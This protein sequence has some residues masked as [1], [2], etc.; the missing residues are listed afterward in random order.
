MSTVGEN[1]SDL[2]L[3][4]LGKIYIKTGNS[5]KL[6]NDVI[7]QI[8]QS[9]SNNSDDY[10]KSITTFTPNIDQVI[11]PEDGHFIFD[12]S[13]KC[14]YIVVNSTPIL[15]M[16]TQQEE[17]NGYVKKSGDT[18]TGPITFNTSQIPIKLNTDIL[19]PRLNAEEINGY[20]SNQ[21]AIKSHDEQITGN[22]EFTDNQKFDKDI[23]LN[24]SIG[25]PTFADGFS[26]YG[27]RL[28][29]TT[30][31]LTVDN[32][33]VRKTMQVYELI[34]NEINATNGSLMVTNSSKIAN[35]EYLDILDDSEAL[36]NQST[37]DK[38]NSLSFNYPVQ[39]YDIGD[40][41][42]I[43]IL[44]N[45]TVQN[46]VD[47]VLDLS[48]QYTF[49]IQLYNTNGDLLDITNY[50]LDINMS[51]NKDAIISSITV[52]HDT[53]VATFIVT[54]QSYLS[55]ITITVHNS[56]Q[57]KFQINGLGDDSSDNLVYN[58]LITYNNVVNIYDNKAENILNKSFKYIQDQ[59]EY[60]H[61]TS[62][63]VQSKI[64]T[65]YIYEY[66]YRRG[67]YYIVTMKEDNYPTLKIGDL[68]RCQK[69]NQ[70]S[71]SIKYYDAIVL[72]HF[73]TYKY[74]I[75]LLNTGNSNEQDI[76][77]DTPSLDTNS[78]EATNSTT[79]TKETS[80]NNSS[81]NTDNINNIIGTKEVNN[82]GASVEQDKQKVYSSTTNSTDGYSPIPAIGDALVQIGSILDTD[83]QGA[84]YI[85]NSDSYAP[86]V[87]VMANIYRPDFSVLYMIPD[88][89]D[90]NQ[91]KT[92]IITNEEGNQETVYSWKYDKCTKARLGNLQ[93]IKDSTFTKRKWY[94]N[95][96]VKTHYSELGFSEDPISDTDSDSGHYYST[97]AINGYGLYSENV[98][99]TGEFYLNNGKSV[100]DFSQDGIYEKYGNAGLYI[101]DDS[102]GG[103]RIRINANKIYIT[104]DTNLDTYTENKIEDSVKAGVSLDGNN[105][106]LFGKEIDITGAVVFHSL[107]TKTYADTS[108]Q[109]A[110]DNITVGGKNIFDGTNKGKTNWNYWK[111]T[112][113]G[114]ITIED[115][116]SDSS[117]TK[118]IVDQQNINESAFIYFTNINR[119]SILNNVQ[120]TLSFDIISTVN[121]TLYIKIQKT[122][123][124]DALIDFGSK[125]ISENINE[126][127]VLTSTTN[128]KT[129]IGQVL[130]I[131]GIKTGTF[132]IKNLKFEIGNKATDWTASANDIS[133]EA[134]D[135]ADKALDAAKTYVA[136]NFVTATLHD[137]DLA[138]L[139]SQ[140]DGAIDTWFYDYVPTNTNIPA[141][142]WTDDATRN[143]HLGDLFYETST[144]YCYRYMLSNSVYSWSRVIDSDATTALAN[145]A[146]AQDTADHKRRIFVVTPI[147]P[148]DVGDMW[149]Q[150]TNGDILICK[151]AKTSTET[152]SI[153]DW[154]LASKY[155]DD[156]TA[157][158]AQ[159]AANAA[160]TT[161]NTAAA[162][163]TSALGTLSN[164]TSDNVLSVS[165]K[166]S[167]KQAWAVVLAEKQNILSQATYFSVSSTDYQNAF[168]ALANYLNNGVTWVSGEPSWLADDS[169]NT[170]I[171][172]DTYRQNWTNLYTQRTLLLNAISTKAKDLADAAQTDATKA[173][174]DASD[175]WNYAKSAKTNA[176]VALGTLSDIT[177]DNILS[178]NEKPAER[179]EWNIVLAEKNSIDLSADTF[180]VSRVSYDNAFTGLANYL[181]NGV[182]WTSG[183][184][185]WLNDTNINSNTTI[186]GTTYRNYWQQYYTTRTTLLNAI[187]DKARIQAD[188]AKDAADDAKS[189][190]DAAQSTA[191]TAK[192]TADSAALLLNTITDDSVLSLNEKPTERQ[193]WDILYNEKQNILNQASTFGI[194]S[195]SYTDAF[196]DLANYLNNGTTWTSGEP[197]WLSDGQLSVNTNIVSSTY[198]S[199][200][201]AVYTARTV[202]LNLIAAKAKTL[203]D[204]AQTDATKALDDAS[205]AFNAAGKAQTDAT[206]ALG[207]ITNIVSDNVLSAAEKSTERKE[208]NIIAAEKSNIDTQANTFGI[209]RTTYDD[210]FQSLATYLNNNTTYTSGIPFWLSDTQLS[211]NT[212]IDG[213]AYR[214]YWSN[215][216]TA[217]TAL[218]NA[219]ASKARDLAKNAQTSA[220]SG[221]TKA[222]NAQKTADAAQA[223]A[224]SALGTLGEITNDNILSPNEKQ[225]ELKEW[226]VIQ[227]EK[228]NID[229]QAG[230][231]QISATAYDTAYTN[232]GTYLNNGVT[233]PTNTTPSTP[234]WFSNLTTN[235]TIDG[236]TYRSKWEAYYEQRTILL[237]ALA[238]KAKDTADS[239][240]TSA[241]AA[242]KAAD[243]AAD[244]ASDA[245][246]KAI[247][248]L[249][250]IGNIVSD[251]ILSPAEK[252]S[253][254]QA[255]NQIVS[256][257]ES[258]D[259]EATTYQITTTDKTN[260]DNYFTALGT[261][262][263]GGTALP[264]GNTP[265]WF[266]DL[267]SNTTIVGTT[268]RSN[269]Q[270]YYSARTTLLNKITAQAKA[271]A[272]QA[273][274]S[275]TDDAVNGIQI[276]GTNLILYSEVHNFGSDS[277]VYDSTNHIWTI[278]IP[279]AP[280]NWGYGFVFGAGSRTAINPGEYLT[281]SCEIYS[282][283]AFTLNHDINNAANDGN[284]W[285]GND[286]DDRSSETNSGF[287]NLLSAGVWHK[288]WFTIKARTDKTVGIQN[289]N[290][291]IGALPQNSA[292]T[293]KV[294]HIKIEKG[295]KATDWTPAPE[296]VTAEVKAAQDSADSANAA[297]SD[298]SNDNK[299]TA[300]EKST[301]RK[302]WDTIYGEYDGI[303]SQAISFGVSY[304]NYTDALVVLGTYLNNNV[305]YTISS[306]STIP[307]LINDTN[308]S[309]TSDINGNTFR[310]NF[311]SFYNERQILLNSISTKSKE[312][313]KTAQDTA[314]QAIDDASDAFNSAH[315]A[316]LALADISNDDLLTP[317]E[318]QTVRKDWDAIYTQYES[319]LTKA[320][321]AVPITSY[322]NALNTLGTYLNN[323]TSYTISSTIPVWINDANLST[324]QSLGTNGGSSFRSH[325]AT[326]YN[327]RQQF[328]T[329]LV[330]YAKQLANTAQNTVDNMQ[331][332]GRNLIPNSDN[333]FLDG[334][335]TYPSSIPCQG[336]IEGWYKFNINTQL[337]G[338]E[339]VTSNTIAITQTGWISESVY[340]KT[341]GILGSCDITFYDNTTGH[342]IIIATIINMGNGI[343]RMEA[344][345]NNPNS[346]PIRT[347]DLFIDT[348][349]AT[350]ISFRYP[351]L[352]Y[353][354]KITD[355]SPAPEDVDALISQAQ[356]TADKAV[357][358]STS[359]YA[360][361]ASSTTAPT[362]GWNTTP[363]TWEQGYY[364]WVRTTI[365]Y[366]DN[367]TTTT[368]PVVVTGNTGATGSGVSI[369]STSITYA[370]SSDSTQPND[371][372]FTYSTVP[373][374][375]T[376]NYLWSKTVVIYSDDTETKSYSVS[377]TG[378]NGTSV[379]ILSTSI[380][381]QV[382]GNGTTVPT[383]TWSGT[384]P[385]AQQGEYLWTKT[386]VNYSDSTSTTTYS[387]AKQ[388][389]TGVGV[390]SITRYYYSTSQS[391]P[392]IPTVLNPPSP[393]TVNEPGYVSGNYLYYT[394]RVL[395][396]DG[397]FSYS[398]VQL[399][400]AYVAAAQANSLLADIS[401]DNKLTPSEKN[402][403]LKEWVTIQ[404]E[405]TPIEKQATT[406]SVDYANYNTAYNNL[407]SYITPLL[408]NM[409]TTSM[410]DSGDNFR[411]KFK[412]YYN[413]RTDLLNAISTMAKTL[414]ENAQ[415]TADN[416]QI[417]G[418][419]LLTNS[420]TFEGYVNYSNWSRADTDY[421]GL[422]VFYRNAQWC[423]L[424]QLYNVVAGKTY[425][426][427]ANVTGDDRC[428][429]YIYASKLDNSQIAGIIQGTYIGNITS[430]RRIRI[431]FTPTESAT[432]YIRVENSVSDSSLNVCGYK[433][434][435]GN[436]A[437]DWSPAPEDIDSQIQ[438]VQLDADSAL[439]S[440]SDISNDKK[441][442][443]LEKQTVN[444]DWLEIQNEYLEYV[445]EAT[446]IGVSTTLYTSY[447]N[448]LST[449]ITPLLSS[450]TSTSNID[451]GDF[452]TNF[453]NYY[454]YRSAL[455][456]AISAK[457]K[458]DTDNIQ[459][460]GVN[461]I[462]NSDQEIVCNQNETNHETT[463]ALIEFNKTYTV[464]YF[465]K[466]SANF[467][468]QTSLLQLYD[469]SGNRIVATWFSDNGVTTVYKRFSHTFTITDSNDI[470]FSLGLRNSASSNIF[471]YY[472]WKLEEGNRATTWTPAIED[473][474]LL[475]AF[476]QD[477][478]VK[479][480]L[481]QTSA[482]F[483]G[484]TDSEGARHTMA[485]TNGIPIAGS[486]GQSIAAWYGGEMIDRQQYD[487]TKTSHYND[488]ATID[489]NA[490]RT[491]FRMDGSGYTA[492]GNLTWDERGILTI[493]QV[494]WDNEDIKNFFNAFSVGLL[495]DKLQITPKG[496]FTALTVGGEKV[497]TLNTL[498]DDT[499]YWGATMISG[500]VTGDINIGGKLYIGYDTTNDAVVFYKSADGG[501]TKEA[502]N[503]YSL[504]GLSAFGENTNISSGGTSYD[505][506]DKWSDY[507]ADKATN[508]L[509]ALLGNDLN[510]RVSKLEGTTLTSVD[511][512]IITNKPST[513]TPSSH[514]HLW[515]DITDH[516]TKLSAFTNDS[517]F[518]TN[519]GTVTSVGLSV[520]TGLSVSGSP[521][522][523]SGTLVIALATG[524]S[525]PTTAKQTN[526]DTAFT[527]NHTHANKTVLDGITS[528]LVANWNTA[529]TNSHTHSNKS[530]LDGITSTLVSNWNS[531]Y[532][533]YTGITATDT[534]NIINK[535][536][537]IIAF[538]DG[539]S[540]STDLNAIISGINGSISD[541][542]TRAKTAESANASNITTLQGYFTSGSAKTAVKLATARTLWGQSFDGTGNVD[543]L[544]E[545]HGSSNQ[546]V[547]GGD[548]PCAI[549]LTN[550]YP[551]IFGSGGEIQFGVSDKDN[552]KNLA[553]IKGIYSDYS[554]SVLGGSIVM[555]TKSV[556]DGLVHEHFRINSLGNIGIGTT[557]PAY[558]LDVNGTLHAAGPVTLDS[559]LSIGGVS[560]FSNYITMGSN[561]INFGTLNSTGWGYAFYA[562][563]KGMNIDC[564]SESLKALGIYADTVTVNGNFLSTGGVTAYTS[565]DR[566]LKM[567]IQPVNSLAVI[568][569]LGGT[570]QFDWKKDGK[571]S[572]GFIAQNVE[573]SKLL[574]MVY[575]GK[576]GYLKLNY[577]DT[578]L[579]SLALGASIQLDDEVTRLRRKVT[580]LEKEVELLKK[581]S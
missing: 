396:T 122:T 364:I 346:Y 186:V 47:Q 65:R 14:L 385:T 397:S 416:I 431:T 111:T 164:I 20:K 119:L 569:T 105:I 41:K 348:S 189:A 305:S 150:G 294:R 488:K 532:S 79:I 112:N 9:T 376:G 72:K 470:K 411:N 7:K 395:Y 484:Y 529:Y 188:S 414:A 483:L 563:D 16:D 501:K 125:A 148:Y 154:E 358:S 318:K 175:A 525:I 266:Q 473:N 279:T 260:Y 4:T 467:S 249:D 456:S 67:S 49:E 213:T 246:R 453:T 98:F 380:T 445:Q 407:D 147:V 199:K 160:Q 333:G 511:W 432:L 313:T 225:T 581:E 328:L 536:Q 312:L 560:S 226:N 13:T 447:Y 37:I 264:N 479:G 353:G 33:I 360:Q 406:F 276:G 556:Q 379:S 194:S 53:H 311:I 512:S 95:N 220:D 120:Y 240:Q 267:T 502:A 168:T 57:V 461:L 218:L 341:D 368:K 338:I 485:G 101:E 382:S 178:A 363:P 383:G 196:Q 321:T 565:S 337:N 115:D 19:I 521:V 458:S 518:T 51:T 452:N 448:A 22:W 531:V 394:D 415:T 195:T 505:R 237:N 545:I 549:R 540:S 36:P 574:S 45:G 310:G 566:R 489:D 299:L 331:I 103:Q 516:P 327:T 97:N 446:N 504:G 227:T 427:S 287:G 562:N 64:T 209:S 455:L 89:D 462:T 165:E 223:S 558:K 552:E 205:D 306:T 490:A 480:G 179:K 555:G 405:K 417:G 553:I 69:F 269:W 75:Q 143:Q 231:F 366:G 219:I 457:L 222:T 334:I 575:H 198:R 31:T 137:Q 403:V 399:S 204:N 270:N 183:T 171:V 132:K 10:I 290:T 332:G 27:W 203:A 291:N 336:N 158:A 159:T 444:K 289:T 535:W 155:T 477:T 236:P 422:H 113:Y 510:T 28:D 443:P 487:A 131:Q 430:W 459:I 528:T 451:R 571:H 548:Y 185:V 24:G 274:G 210:N 3:Q 372:A 163:A 126:H 70:S 335:Y 435:E 421:Q 44:S 450:L 578:R 273:A 242:Q 304:T 351:Q 503:V 35:V 8:N 322:T 100:V 499:T 30:N 228:S 356:T 365:T 54:P 250:N 524:Y 468:G 99:L 58:K 167:E 17:S 108:A 121:T 25:T 243:A 542:V 161:A 61:A 93:G 187:S 423:G 78:G 398:N 375:Y 437:T 307:S 271:L 409:T 134:Q 343:Y 207:N 62:E 325:F 118:V 201:V 389:E 486:E 91:L 492:K 190:A 275:Y 229:T 176:D 2:I 580:R 26:G 39:K 262:L 472:R 386:V 402:D 34:I 324:K 12:L 442:T 107:A 454:Q 308:L 355:W 361:S 50:L 247:N 400:S 193:A 77:K 577:L 354:N 200:W 197:L 436:K 515:A 153:N 217:R 546:S 60:E 367:T 255:W 40:I 576:D 478:T 86:Y 173:L 166:Q 184:P 465:L 377:R 285:S 288:V 326:F 102:N 404:G 370:I 297:I 418:R 482:L 538:L 106:S 52:N 543:G 116:S 84:V 568:R 340:I 130:T 18:M 388:G 384:I 564:T 109:T 145:A 32:I 303:V 55:T 83:R 96:Y 507:T 390:E 232:L 284:N 557:S 493:K 526:W 579:I 180:L 244:D 352:E 509:S 177:S 434:E 141:S 424:A 43:R 302:E 420:K 151:T 256:E 523:A 211:V 233:L 438:S 216:Y 278:N 149:S 408:G 550:F 104:S 412:T 320:S 23:I 316:N 508:V 90:N 144:G 156:T 172:G 170:T 381:Y 349:N 238:K 245:Y 347:I 127:I 476:K 534:D 554:N 1:T 215:L 114:N 530:V 139:Q 272:E 298:I 85:T 63:T 182:T 46:V 129:N 401:D 429:V 257:K 520:P 572:I 527:N 413:S 38:Y 463:H 68:V 319:D 373:T 239:A 169:V 426:F 544:I 362:T 230:N 433:L 449:Y 80:T 496:D 439:A 330:D 192:E 393:W 292:Y 174:N 440:L 296:D 202:L 491:L 469:I 94:S 460:G 300:N 248:A 224:D 221:I 280:S 252:P 59:Y 235:Q 140:I 282:D 261:Y 481:I 29:N 475:N 265:L 258:Y 181:N 533:W 374:V 88:Y 259:A 136:Q 561:R 498:M 5:K 110:A 317:D 253:Q 494:T 286:N 268:Y 315:N 547:L 464:S 301:V 425:T 497:L 56:Y 263:N 359:E 309:V 117:I 152:Y 66:Y 87:D 48:D 567:N 541:E 428:V 339:I 410:L 419:N 344:S 392:S 342:H 539:I 387:V 208:W 559:S 378:V 314:N 123:S 135:K 206:T 42:I 323:G 471:T 82:N 281:Y 146:A 11:V 283:V 73:T 357:I 551:Y 466:S 191:D 519:I 495:N 212:T 371:S 214:T 514:T 500:K 162:N 15:I 138:N 369:S 133:Q 6:L 128:S 76:S 295:N 474:Y 329:A 345:Y 251:N 74:V 71:N 573:Q 537:E 350:Y 92:N 570:F 517:G 391:T 142:D 441:L 277:F 124:T 522:T 81:I 506:L 234:S 293:I 157:N 21:L 254:L 513:F 241:D